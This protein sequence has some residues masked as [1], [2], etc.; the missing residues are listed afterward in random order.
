MKIMQI[1]PAL[2]LGGVERGT[3]DLVKCL[4]L[5]GIGS[6]VV[7]SGGALVKE[8]EREGIPHYALPVHKK[9][10]FTLSL[11]PRLVEI[12]EKERI[13]VVHA[14]SRV[15]GWIAWLAARKAGVPFVTTCHGYYSTH[16]LSRIMGWGTRVIVP[17]QV[18][19][20][21]MIDDFGV[22]PERIVVIPRG[23]DFS[24][25]SF[26]ADKY[27]QPAPKVFRVL[28]L[29]RLSPIKGQLEFLKAL[30]QV[31]QK[32]IPVEGWLAGSE[33]EGKTEYTRQIQQTLRQLGLERNVKLLGTRRDVAK[34]LG[35]ADL[36][37]LSTL[38]PESFGRVL[39]EAGAVG[40]ACI[41]TRLGGALEIIGDGKEG[42]LVPPRDERALAEAMCRL[43]LNRKE[44]GEMASR[45]HEKVKC[46]YSLEQMT[47]KTLTVYLNVKRRKRILV[48]KRGALGDVILVAPSLRMIRRKF[49]HAHVSVL[50]D[51]RFA[52]V[53]SNCPYVDEIIPLDP[54]KMNSWRALARLAKRLRRENYDISIDFQNT[55]RTHFLAFLAG[56]PG[57]YGFRRGIFGRL[58]N[59][60]DL[61]F[62][63]PETPVRHQFRVLSKLGISSLDETLELWPDPALE[64]QA[65]EWLKEKGISEEAKRVGLAV[66]SSARWATKRWPLRNFHALA[67]RLH[68]ELGCH[69]ILL[70]S[71]QDRDLL[72]EIPETDL[73]GNALL[74][75]VGE[76]SLKELIALVK[77]LD[78]VVT[79]DTAPLHIAGALGVR[80]VALFGPTDPKRH[81]PE[82]HGIH[83]L[84]KR[85]DCRPCYR[86]TCRNAEKLACLNRISVE[87]VFEAVRKGLSLSQK[88]EKSPSVSLS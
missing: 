28:N 73:K 82:G 58:L 54:E 29:G 24:E 42:L 79:G 14:R 72:K 55:K 35:E 68:T 78:L 60:P 80:S 2:E 86:G 69:V 38:I 22:P 20:R 21:H 66:G 45:L 77:Q 85:L 75:V 34:L 50:V 8:I 23:V 46:E 47:E 40:T 17:S 7:S 13:E 1:L 27:N 31:R 74:S 25:F 76:T 81:A 49:P 56:I 5:H 70:G 67:K 59:H 33:G 57:R 51:S 71:L 43:L 64:N 39:I 83:V 52:P 48:I 65:R 26:I 62:S 84:T 9:S 53:I 19:A 11:V 88:R 10:L 36:L 87:E 16:G 37:V 3:V 61:T 63:K 44:A 41:A 18:I 6:V 4:K 30:H 12:I 15:P 32:G